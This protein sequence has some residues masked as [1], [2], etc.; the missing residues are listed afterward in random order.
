MPAAQ[1]IGTN[2][3]GASKVRNG[4]IANSRAKY[5]NT[6]LVSA[7]DLADVVDPNKPLTEKAKLFVK[8]WASGES[9]AAASARAGYGEGATY[10][11]RLVHY[12]QVIALYNEEKRK[13]EEAAQMTRKKVMDMHIEAFE[14]AKLL[15]EPASMVAAAREIG[16][17]CG[18]YEPVK[19]RIELTVNGQVEMKRLEQLSDSEL[20]KLLSEGVAQAAPAL[21]EH[22]KAA[23]D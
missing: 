5:T 2:K 23:E 12:P 16:K 3:R 8:L 19:Q 20:L 11:Y 13:Y 7:K 14:M 9:I 17:M 15:S 4:T 10:A 22:A 21:L 18:Y 1:Y 6:A